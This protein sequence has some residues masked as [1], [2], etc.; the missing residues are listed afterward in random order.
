MDKDLTDNPS[1]PQEVVETISRM[2]AIISERWGCD[3]TVPF[4]IAFDGKSYVGVR[5]DGRL[6]VID[7]ATGEP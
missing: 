5:V 7:L 6:C 3:E 4:H 2:K 1:I